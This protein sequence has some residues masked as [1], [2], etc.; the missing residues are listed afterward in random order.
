MMENLI[1]GDGKSVSDETERLGSA[2][3]ASALAS[4]LTKGPKGKAE[5]FCS[6]GLSGGTRGAAEVRHLR[7]AGMTP[8]PALRQGLACCRLVFTAWF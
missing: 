1:E 3:L 6:S 8:P 5:T 7:K 4:A 2:K